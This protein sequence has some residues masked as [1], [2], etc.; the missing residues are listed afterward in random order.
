MTTLHIKNMVCNRCK[1]VVRAVLENLGLTV[2]RVDLGEADITDW[3]A[4][5]TADQV[6]T[7]LINNEF[8]LLDDPKA[9]LVEQL[10]TLIIGEIHGNKPRKPAYQNFSDFL[11]NQ[12]GQDY[13]ALSHLFSA[14]E[15]LTIEKFII[16]QRVERVKE[17]LTDSEASISEIAFQ[18]SYSS[19]AHLSNQFKQVTGQTPGAFRQSRGHRRGLD[20]VTR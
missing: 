9:V 1:R 20:E 16:A 3:P 17:L 15:G 19:V 4:H 10:K 6:R 2:T 12:T 18:L 14:M 5:L 7:A 8:D 11:A 13:G